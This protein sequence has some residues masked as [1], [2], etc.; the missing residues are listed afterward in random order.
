[1]SREIVD[2]RGREGR[3]EGRREKGTLRCERG[4]GG[5]EATRWLTVSNLEMAKVAVRCS[6]GIWAVG[7]MEMK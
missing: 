7:H 1:M 4:E 5:T 2:H 3:R 6:G